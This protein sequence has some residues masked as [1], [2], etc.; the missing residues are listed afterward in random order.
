MATTEA[1]EG[2]SCWVEVLDSQNVVTDTKEVFFSVLA[3]SFDELVVSDGVREA[4]DGGD[5]GAVTCL[6]RCGSIFSFWC[7]QLKGGCSSEIMRG[8]ATIL[9]CL[10]LGMISTRC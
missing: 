9:G 3:T 2:A 6:E 4:L 7:L 5:S 8:V 10:L 1:M